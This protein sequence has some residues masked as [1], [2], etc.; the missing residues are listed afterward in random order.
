MTG[1]A[2]RGAGGAE[3]D[4]I[5]LEVVLEAKELWICVQSVNRP[6]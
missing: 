4:V 5:A 2:G 1:L 6:S 3:D